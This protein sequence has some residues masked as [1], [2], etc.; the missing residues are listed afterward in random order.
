MGPLK[1]KKK[2]AI[3]EIQR[4]KFFCGFFLTLSYQPHKMKGVPPAV[5]TSVPHF[6]RKNVFASE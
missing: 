5:I 4:F 1:K 2:K 6:F 3:S